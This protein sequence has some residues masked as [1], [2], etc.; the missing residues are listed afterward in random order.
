[1]WHEQ[2]LQLRSPSCSC[3]FK[4]EKRNVG[5]ILTQPLVYSKAWPV[6]PRWDEEQPAGTH[7]SEK[8]ISSAICCWILQ[9]LVTHHYCGNEWLILFLKWKLHVVYDLRSP[10]ISLLDTLTHKCIRRY[11]KWCWRQRCLFCRTR[12][13]HKSN[14]LKMLHH[15]SKHRSQPALAED[16]LSF[17]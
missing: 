8:W 17:S 14:I 3:C 12:L 4:E 10:F 13:I 11:L 15:L 7:I 5:W 16:G 6:Q 2:R 1:M 9:W